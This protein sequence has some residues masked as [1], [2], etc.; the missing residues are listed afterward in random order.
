MGLSYIF[1][2]G[3]KES[4]NDC[5]LRQREPISF[6]S[7]ISGVISDPGTWHPVLTL[8][9]FCRLCFFQSISLIL[10]KQELGVRVYR[11]S[12]AAAQAKNPETQTLNSKGQRHPKPYRRTPLDSPEPSTLNPLKP[13]F[14]SSQIRN[15]QFPNP[16]TPPN[17]KP[18]NPS[19]KTFS[20]PET[21]NP[22]TP[23]PKP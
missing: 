3:N 5:L 7:T 8:T 21:L 9:I 16:L 6:Q 1:L 4:N 12:R 20:P 15:H 17:P 23:H 14:A 22:E 2:L 10:Q 19:P 11:V 13:I 18:R